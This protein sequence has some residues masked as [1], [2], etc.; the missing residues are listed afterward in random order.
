MQ[1]RTILGFP[2]EIVDKKH[3]VSH[4]IKVFCSECGND[5]LYITKA[6]FSLRKDGENIICVNCIYKEIDDYQ[7]GDVAECYDRRISSGEN[8]SHPEIKEEKQDEF[9][10]MIK[11]IIEGKYN[12]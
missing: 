12:V 8:I 2:K 11:D 5:N 9:K 10:K 1:K 7:I 3:F 4:H 6:L